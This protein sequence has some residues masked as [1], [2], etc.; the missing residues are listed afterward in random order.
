MALAAV[1]VALGVLLS[2]SSAQAATVH[3][4]LAKTVDEVLN[5][6]RN[7]IL[8]ILS[9][10]AAA[11]LTIG[12]LRYLMAGGDP[13]EVEKAKSAFKHAG[14]GF[15]LAALAPIVVDAFKAIVGGGV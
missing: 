3:L 1:L 9:A 15:C 5:N 6:I 4:A 2:S 10:I 8:G 13:G 14:I 11:F 12:G 7:W